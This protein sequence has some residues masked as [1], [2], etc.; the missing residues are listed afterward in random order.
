LVALKEKTTMASVP[1]NERPHE[2]V[3]NEAAGGEPI[4]GSNEPVM[5]KEEAEAMERVQEEA[6]EERKKGGYQ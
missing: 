1:E 3:A 4:D 2:P 5:P 6:A